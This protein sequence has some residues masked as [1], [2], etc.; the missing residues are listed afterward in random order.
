MRERREKRIEERERR[1]RE[2]GREETV[3]KKEIKG[4]GGETGKIAG[5]VVRRRLGGG[6]RARDGR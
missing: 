6:Q 3:R 5:W 4:E 1:E 2:R